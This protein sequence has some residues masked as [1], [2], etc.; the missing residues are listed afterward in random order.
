MRNI[1]S[2][3]EAQKASTFDLNL[4]VWNANLA[5]GQKQEFNWVKFEAGSRYPM[6]Q[7]PYEQTSIMI[8]GRM[9]LT[10]GD[11]S[12]EV[13]PGDM[14]FAPANLPHGGEIIGDAPIVFVEVYSAPSKGDGSDVTYL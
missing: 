3:S 5:T 10:V 11:E 9:I 7:H 8:E 13:G 14:W 2:Q 6:H 4:R 1:F 12:R